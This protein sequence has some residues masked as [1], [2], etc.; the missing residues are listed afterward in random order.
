MCVVSMIID[1]F[2]DRWKPQPHISPYTVPFVQPQVVIAPAPPVQVPTKEE[3]DEFHRLLE[4]ARQWDIEHGEPD[5]GTE[6]KRQRLKELA[7]ELGIE[8]SFV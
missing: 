6:E 1:D 2:H 5:C 4:K 3:I 7:D 8:I